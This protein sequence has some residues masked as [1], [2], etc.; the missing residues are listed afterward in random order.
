VA[1]AVADVRQRL[2]AAA[3]RSGRDPE[4]VRLVAVTKGVA[5]ERTLQVVDA[6]VADL[7]ESRAQELL[8]K[9]PALEGRDVS[10]HFVGR[11][12]RNKV[13]PLAPLVSLWHS[14]DR[15]ELGETIARRAPGARVLVEVN[16]AAD[17]HNGGCHPAAAP[18]L[19][20]QLD[21]LG[22]K[23]EGLMTVPEFGV[24]PRPAFRSLRDLGA[25]LGLP[26]LSMGMSDDF[27]AAVEEGATIVR[28]GRALFS[29]HGSSPGGSSLCHWGPLPQGPSEAS[30]GPSI[31]ENRPGICNDGC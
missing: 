24:D 18:A 6:G 8:G 28:V 4:A 31:R 16:V 20:E 10:W 27:E 7:G 26:E 12:Q 17:P 15:A 21:R 13:G 5:A 25:T 1:A 19:V 23:V 11:L 9:V 2:A 29:H 22:L 3:R 30:F 14:V